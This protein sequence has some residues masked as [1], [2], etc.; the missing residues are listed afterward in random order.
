MGNAILPNAIICIPDLDALDKFMGFCE[1][2]D[3]PWDNNFRIRRARAFL[4]PY[5]EQHHGEVCVNVESDGHMGY[6]YA[7]YYR[8]NRCYLSQ[9]PN[10]NFC[11]VEYFIEEIS[12]RCHEEL[13]DFDFDS[14]L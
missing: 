12:G 2:C 4:V 1:E 9:D 10:L 6:C 13:H 3:I 7:D 14:I 5:M 8:R 11:S